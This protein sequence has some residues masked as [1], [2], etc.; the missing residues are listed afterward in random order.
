M[1][2]WYDITKNLGAYNYNATSDESLH[3]DYHITIKDNISPVSGLFLDL[4]SNL[5]NEKNLIVT[6]PDN[7][8]R[9]IPLLSFIYAFNFNKSVLVFTSHHKDRRFNKRSLKDYHNLNYCMLSMWGSYVFYSRLIG[10]IRKNTLKTD[11]KFTKSSNKRRTKKISQELIKRLENSEPKVLL[12][13]E[14]ELKIIDDVSEVQIDSKSTT[15]NDSSLDLGLVIFENV[16][17]YVN[18]RFTTKKFLDWI[19][20]YQEKG[21]RCLFHF[22]NPNSKFIDVIK[23]ETNSFVIPLNQDLLSKTYIKEESEN[24]FSN[25]DQFPK[26]KEIIDN[27]NLD[28]LNFLDDGSF[29]SKDHIQIFE[30]LIKSGNFKYYYSQ[31]KNILKNINQKK[32]VNKRLFGISKKLFYSFQELSVNPLR[33]NVKFC[34]KDGDCKYYRTTGFLDIFKHNLYKENDPLTHELL[35][36][37]IDSLFSITF[38]LGRSK[39]YGEDDSFGRI[40][41][42]YCILDIAKNKRKYFGNDNDLI[43]C[44]YNSIEVSILENELNRFNIKNVIVKNIHWL[45]KSLW[46]L[47]IINLF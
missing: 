14:D 19:K 47:A 31:G 5:I 24:Y 3:S 46:G 23:K 10:F 36:D 17:L 40:G 43:I 7:V 12:F 44:C 27:Y 8:F 29:I 39:H 16:D 32:V 11:I 25:L 15:L 26:R 37:F 38:E 6:F 18:S 4:Y 30:P 1:K 2:S 41:K 13:T 20:K 42:E 33:Y 22:S 34:E 28:S 35:G 21:I 9:L 45:N